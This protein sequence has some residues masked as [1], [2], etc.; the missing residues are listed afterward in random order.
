MNM[1]ISRPRECTLQCATL[2]Q[3]TGQTDAR[4]RTKNVVVKTWAGYQEN[5]SSLNFEF[6]PDN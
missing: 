2:W 3:Q 4:I 6:K 1:D 5:S